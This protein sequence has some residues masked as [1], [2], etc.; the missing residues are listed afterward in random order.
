MGFSANVG[1]DAAAAYKEAAESSGK[2][3]PLPGGKYQATIVPLDEKNGKQF[4]I[5]DFSTRNPE[6]AGKKA[7]RVRVRI[8]DGS[9]TG[10]KRTFFDRIPLFTRFAPSPKNPQGAPARNYFGFF[11]AVG[12]TEEQIVSGNFPFELQHLLGKQITITLSD[13]VLPDQYNELGSNE[14]SFYGKPGSV[15]LTPVRVPGQP[16]APWLDADDELLPGFGGSEAQGGPAAPVAAPADPWASQPVT[17][18]PVAP[19]AA[20]APVGDPWAPAAPAAPV[21]DPGLAAAAA[22]GGSF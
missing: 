1:P 12:A 4:D 8:V 3:P 15:E 9:P 17:P 22:S 14:V 16:V 11:E 19:V 20:S 2:F 21:A 6:Y 13:P 10:A 7:L 5:V 18:Q